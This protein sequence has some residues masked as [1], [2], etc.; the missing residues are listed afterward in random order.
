M[1]HCGYIWTSVVPLDIIP[2]QAAGVATADTHQCPLPAEVSDPQL[3][4][5]PYT[6]KSSSDRPS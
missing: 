4:A 5:Y 6:N 1:L 2:R 3:A